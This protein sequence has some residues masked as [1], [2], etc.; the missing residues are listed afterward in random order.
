M[1]R[2]APPD[3]STDYWLLTT[4]YC[5]LHHR[6]V[7]R[8]RV[9]AAVIDDVAGAVYEFELDGV[10]ARRPAREPDG[11]PLVEVL[12]LAAVHR[13]AHAVLAAVRLELR[14]REPEVDHDGVGVRPLV[15][16]LRPAEGRVQ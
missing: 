2:A 7:A 9:V 4:G 15:L 1:M 14:V 12:R 16:A 10:L 11:L 13:V 8:G 3:F 5:L 6:D